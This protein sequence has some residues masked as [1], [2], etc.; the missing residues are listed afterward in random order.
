MMV[1]MSL[2]ARMVSR[3]PRF[4]SHRGQRFTRHISTVVLQNQDLT[5]FQESPLLSPASRSTKP[6]RWLGRS[7]R[8]TVQTTGLSRLYLSNV[9][10]MDHVFVRK[11]SRRHLDRSIVGQ[12][13]QSC[14][15]DFPGL[16]A[17]T[18]CITRATCGQWVATHQRG[19]VAISSAVN[20]TEI[21][22]SGVYFF[23]HGTHGRS[24]TPIRARTAGFRLASGG[25]WQS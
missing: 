9:L 25:M 12:L 21:P 18:Y 23:L 8:M 24:S 1:T 5:L 13:V 6:P 15:L 2:S 7:V 17:S 14:H 22:A 3:M 16:F 19:A 20:C 11:L 10:T 4:P